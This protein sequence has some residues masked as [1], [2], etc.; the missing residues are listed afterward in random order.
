MAAKYSRPIL[1]RSASGWDYDP[2]RFT[3][4]LANERPAYRVY[5]TFLLL[6]HRWLP[7]IML[8]LS[9]HTS[10]YRR[11]IGAANMAGP[12]SFSLVWLSHGT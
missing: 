12:C 3:T 7:R 5:Q 4:S 8:F 9:Y 6:R 1:S 10:S 2:I 11:A